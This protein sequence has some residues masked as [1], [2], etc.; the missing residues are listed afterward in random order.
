MNIKHVAVNPCHSIYGA[1]QI[2]GQTL[3]CNTRCSSVYG[4]WPWIAASAFL[5]SRVVLWQA[6]GSGAPDIWMTF[7]VV[8]AEPAILRAKKSASWGAVALA[9]LFVGMVAGGKYTGLS[10]AA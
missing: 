6:A 8:L 9:G 7:F 1:A 10:L 3:S 2:V 5:L 4:V